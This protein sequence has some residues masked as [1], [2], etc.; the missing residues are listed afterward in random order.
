MRKV[1]QLAGVLLA[2]ACVMSSCNNG[3]GASCSKDLSVDS[4][5]DS[6]AYALGLDLGQNVMYRMI[7]LAPG[8][9]IGDY[10][11]QFPVE[12]SIPMDVYIS[13]LV[14]ALKNDTINGVMDD[15]TKQEVILSF[16]KELNE[17]ME[18]KAIMNKIQSDSALTA[19]KAKE[20]VQV[21]ASGLQYRVITEG[22]GAKP[23]AKD[24]VLVHYVGKLVDGTIFD[25]SAN[26]GPEP[27]KFAANLVIPGW[28]EGL[29]LMK[30]GAKYEFL[31]PSELAYGERG[32]MGIAPNSALWFEV[33]LVDVRPAKK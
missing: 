22:T 28:T 29:Q 9:N 19:N 33:E 27:A 10:L 24:T 17:I 25:A 13:G 8:Q 6:V 18:K 21:T 5:M 14:A 7:G 26:H 20:G 32:N 2:T 15:E 30:E 23:T 16:S 12:D 1:F 4:H 31:I 3:N 11:S